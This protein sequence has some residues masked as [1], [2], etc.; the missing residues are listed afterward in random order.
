[1]PHKFFSKTNV[2]L[3]LLFILFVFLEY[4]WFQGAMRCVINRSHSGIVVTWAV[5]KDCS[6]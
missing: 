4:R 5:V 6:Y 1:M 2:L 3:T